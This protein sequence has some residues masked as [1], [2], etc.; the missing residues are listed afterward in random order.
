MKP[1]ATI[2]L[3]SC[4]ATFLVAAPDSEK[5]RDEKAKKS[6]ASEDAPERQLSEE[7]L[8]ALELGRKII[9]AKAALQEPGKQGSIAAIKDLG[10]DSR[11]YVLVRGWIVQHI[12]MTESYKGTSTYKNSD[13]RR[14]EID[15]RIAA[16]QK[17]L[18][19]TDLE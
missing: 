6:K 14:K 4:S 7:D 5:P 17:M 8:H 18:R 9:R 3:L 2:L 16:L 13:K 19:A 12:S 1:L 11:Y 10:L 15:G